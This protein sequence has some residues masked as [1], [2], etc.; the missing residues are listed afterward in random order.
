MV[1]QSHYQIYKAIS[2]RSGLVFLSETKKS[3]GGEGRL[4]RTFY[5]VLTKQMQKTL[6]IDFQGVLG[7]F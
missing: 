3:A 4:K 1:F 6:E 7:L 5:K 2:S